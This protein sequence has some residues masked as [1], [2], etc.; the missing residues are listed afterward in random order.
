MHPG[1]EVFA[2][3]TAGTGLLLIVNAAI[4]GNGR[5]VPMAV[6][7]GV[8]LTMAGIIILTRDKVSREVQ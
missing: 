1:P 4:L 8:T 2:P 5:L 7:A 6:I 3:C